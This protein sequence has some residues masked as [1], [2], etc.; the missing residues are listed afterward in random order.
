M[1]PAKTQQEIVDLFTQKVQRVAKLLGELASFNRT[2]SPQFSQVGS[3]CLRL[4]DES[5]AGK[6]FRDW[7]MEVDNH[8]KQLLYYGNS[9]EEDWDGAPKE[10]LVRCQKAMKSLSRLLQELAKE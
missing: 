10:L 1:Y 3:L 8:P 4:T 6:A 2:D 9:T 7:I 5:L